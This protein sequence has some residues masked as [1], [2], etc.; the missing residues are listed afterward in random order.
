MSTYINNFANK[1]LAFVSSYFSSAIAINTVVS[2]VLIFS[3]INHSA[4]QEKLYWFFTLTFISLLRVANHLFVSNTYT[5]KYNLYFIGLLLTALT[6]AA[7]P[8][9]F[10]ENMGIQEKFVSLV[11]FSSLAGGGVNVL[12]SDIR[13]S[14]SYITCLLVPFSILL[15]LQ[16]I[17]DERVL[18]VLGLVLWFILCFI[19]AVRS[20]RDV[21]SSINNELKLDQFIEN[22]ENEVQ[23]RT[24]QIILLEQKDNLTKLFNRGSF[25]S[26]V[27]LD[28]VNENSDI[29]AVLF[30]D[31]DDFKIINDKYGH[32]FGDYVLAQI[33]KRLIDAQ[34]KG[35]FIACRWGGDEFIFYS[36]NAT[37]DELYDC[38]FRLVKTLTQ[39]V[40]LNSFRVKPSFKIGLYFTRKNFELEQAIKYADVAMYDGKRS[41]NEVSVFDERMY[42]ALKREDTLRNAIHKCID[43]G[44]FH[45]C[46]QPIVN[47]IDN[48]ITTFEVLLRWQFNDEFIPASE[49][50]DIAERYG[51]INQ[52]GEFVLEQS[53]AS[54]GKLN[55][56]DPSIALSINVSVLQLENHNF[57]IIL[58]DLLKK[59]AVTPSNVHLEITE[60]VMIKNLVY[61]SEVITQIK[62]TGVR[63][64]ID[65]FGTGFSSISV[66]K[67]LSVDYIKI[68][69]SYIDN[70]CEHSTDENIVSAVTK[71]SHMIGCQVVAEGVENVAQ[72]ALLKTLHIDKYQG[73]LFSKPVKFTDAIKL[74]G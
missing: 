35:D 52:L 69:K 61:L 65:D 58:T 56:V 59:Y 37:E 51:K 49:F 30:L 17:E 10:Y 3:S 46:Y 60:T 38:I 18:G 13:S 43:K 41:R 53:I 22:L 73:F 55:E 11:V 21:K 28:L 62:E 14:L 64:S 26:N 25:V 66:L 57:L 15:L 12:A 1:R 16:P 47:M 70:I 72:L 19:T 68:D 9:L 32:E 39:T 36:R 8:V 33:G 54:L 2:C 67:E 74:I 31:M 44:D 23:S 5:F 29:K 71:M 45:L 24:E 42:D 63:I 50:I 6:W 7:F 27:E 4:S 20:A 34:T 40:S 48:K